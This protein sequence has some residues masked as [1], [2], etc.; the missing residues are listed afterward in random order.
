MVVIFVS[1]SMRENFLWLGPPFIYQILPWSKASQRNRGMLRSHV[2]WS[3][4]IPPAW[5]RPFCL[6]SIS[7]ALLYLLCVH[8]SISP[9]PRH[10]FLAP[11]EQSAR[12][13]TAYN[14]KRMPW[15]GRWP[16]PWCRVGVTYMHIEQMHAQLH[17]LCTVLPR[18]GDHLNSEGD[19][20]LCNIQHV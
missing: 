10:H 15:A 17:V 13:L 9:G 6:C 8:L 18:E 7:H 1:Y 20:H 14:N 12:G 2:K 4:L 11:R 5:S 19:P 16:R 3:E